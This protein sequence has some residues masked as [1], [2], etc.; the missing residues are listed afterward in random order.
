MFYADP[1]PA[2]GIFDDFMAIPSNQSD[3]QTRSFVNMFKS[4]GEVVIFPPTVR[5]VIRF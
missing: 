4:L 3:V 5:Y 1:T 2:P